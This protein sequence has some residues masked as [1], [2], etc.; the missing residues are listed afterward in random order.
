MHVRFAGV[1][2]AVSIGWVCMAGS[3]EAQTY[4]QQPPPGYV[5]QPGYA[6][7]P[8]GY[9][10]MG[11]KVIRTYQDGDPIPPGYHPD[12]RVRLGLVIGG[13]SIFGGVYLITALVAA[14]INDT[15]S[16]DASLLYIP[17]F[18]PF[19]QI[20]QTKDQGLIVAEIFTGLLQ[21][22]GVAMFIAGLAAPKTVLVR[23]DIGSLS[24]TPVAFGNGGYGVG[25]VGTF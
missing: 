4:A 7:P 18:G 11:P 12:T 1:V 2:G 8:P 19:A 14:T 22:G 3:A 25:A 24:V 16:R 17:V 23:N 15:S 10:P 20:S 21:A 9:A 6:P 5:Q 13:A